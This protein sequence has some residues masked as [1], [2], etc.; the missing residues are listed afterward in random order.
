VKRNKEIAVRAFAQ[1]LALFASLS[2]AVAMPALAAEL[3]DPGLERLAVASY[4]ND[5]RVS[6]EEATRR[7]RLQ[8]RAA[9]IE[10]RIEAL[11]GEQFAGAWFDHDDRGRFKIGITRAAAS[12][13]GDVQR[14]VGEFGLGDDA[15]LVS[16]RYTLAELERNKDAIR[17][18]L[19]DMMRIGHAITAYDTKSNAVIVSAL[20]QL[21]SYEETRIRA[22]ASMDGVIV[23]RVAGSTLTAEPMCTILYCPPPLRGARHMWFNCTGGFIARHRVYTGDFLMLTVGHCIEDWYWSGYAFGAFSAPGNSGNIG[24]PYGYVY[25]GNSGSDAGA[26]YIDPNEDWAWPLPV[27]HVIVESSLLTTYNPNYK[28]KQDSKST[29]GQ[30]LCY[31]GQGS[32]THCAEVSLLGVDFINS[33]GVLLK[34]FGALHSCSVAYGDSGAPIYKI[35][36]GFGLINSEISMLGTCF[37]LYQGIRSVENVLNVDILTSP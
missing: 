36:R 28:I 22:L 4:V 31:S 16:V 13:S 5:H 33:E 20:E 2:S 24:V 19:L 14:I 37:A 23:R 3:E 27:P 6:A 1:N 25:G 21:P 7:L 10:D 17:E 11:L 34:N 26:I 18:S 15:Q 8:D 30:T 12:R 29:L 32:K 9:G 35:N